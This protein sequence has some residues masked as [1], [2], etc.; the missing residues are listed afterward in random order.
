MV[1]DISVAKKERQ[2]A[3]LFILRRLSGV[4]SYIN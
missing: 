3:I 2:V 4:K 1:I